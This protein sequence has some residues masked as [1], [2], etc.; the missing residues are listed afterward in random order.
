MSVVFFG[1]VFVYSKFP[2]VFEEKSTIG[3]YL[4]LIELSN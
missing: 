2:G 3:I 4:V 1:S